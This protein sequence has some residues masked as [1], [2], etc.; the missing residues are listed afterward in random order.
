MFVATIT[1]LVSEQPGVFS[2]RQL[3]L[4]SDGVLGTAVHE[5]GNRL[6][7]FFFFAVPLGS[8]RAFVSGWLRNSHPPFVVLG[9]VFK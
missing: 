6:P 8:R 5:A 9:W 3:V 2:A 7:G 1:A 4:Q